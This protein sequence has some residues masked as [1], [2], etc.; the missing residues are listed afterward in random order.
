MSSTPTQ[1]TDAA[2][3]ITLDQWAREASRTDARVELLNAFVTTE[4]AAGHRRR[5]RAEWT[6]AYSAFQ[7]RP[8][9]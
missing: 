5:S 7:A 3:V 6:S 2:E 8:V 9:I 4:A 1:P